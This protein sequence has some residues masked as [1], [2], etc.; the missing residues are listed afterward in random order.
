MAREIEL[1][2]RVDDYRVLMDRI[3]A[4]EG[5]SP[6]VAEHKADIYLSRP[7]EKKHFRVRLQADCVVITSKTKEKRH[8]GT[9]DNHEI[10]FGTDADSYP[11]V[12]EFF[13]SLGFE[14]YIRKEKTG[15][16]WSLGRM[17]VE[18]V[19]VGPLGW[20]LEMEIVLGDDASEVDAVEAKTELFGL[21]ERLGIGRENLE[22]RY[23]MDLLRE[24]V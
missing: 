3:N 7:G 4:I 15:W 20:F 24:Q 13:Y 18:L 2:A 9:E 10:E 11:H 17:T 23:Y 16:L 19:Q 5:I 12:L 22:G 1:K 8:D 6:P 14:D 21:L